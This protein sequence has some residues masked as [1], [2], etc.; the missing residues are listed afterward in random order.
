[1]GGGIVAVAVAA[2]E[3]GAGVAGGGVRPQAASSSEQSTPSPAM[4]A[5]DRARIAMRRVAMESRGL[6]ARFTVRGG[7]GHKVDAGLRFLHRAERRDDH[8][9]AMARLERGGRAVLV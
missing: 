5:C 6:L 8:D 1:M 4:R 3:V 7:I 2:G 9:P